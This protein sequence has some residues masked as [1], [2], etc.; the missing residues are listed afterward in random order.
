MVD[1]EALESVLSTPDDDED[2][3]FVRL[4]QVGWEPE[5]LDKDEFRER[6]GADLEEEP[7][8]GCTEH[9]VGWMNVRYRGVEVLFVYM[10]DS[11]L[12]DMYYSRYSEIQKLR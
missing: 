5:E 9:N 3:G 6:N 12:W 8:E 4:V 1:Q 2:K 10:T 11:I 7:L